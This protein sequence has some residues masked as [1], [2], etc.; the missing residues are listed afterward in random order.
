MTALS[1]C[2]FND[3]IPQVLELFERRLTALRSDD[4]AV[5][6]GDQKARAA[7]H[8]V[9]RWH[10]G[11]RLREVM[12][13]WGHLH[14]ILVDELES[15]SAGHRNLKP[16]VMH[17]ARRA[18]SL[19]CSEGVS[20]SAARYA[21]FQQ[22]DAMGRVR[23]LEHAINQIKALERQRA[24]FWR[25]AAH[26]LRGNLGVVRSATALLN[27]TSITDPVRSQFMAILDR[28]VESL[29]TLLT[30][31]MTL[32]RLEAGQERRRIAPFD[33]AAALGELCASLEPG[34]GERGLFLKTKGP[35]TLP[36]EGD[37]MRTRRIAQ[38]L[39]LNAIKY[40]ERGG[41]KVEWNV[42]ANGDDEQ[43]CL[44]VEDT[45]PGFEDGP[46][47]P[48]ARLLKQS[49]EESRVVEEEAEDA[50]DPTANP[51]PAPT[52]ASQST[53][54]PGNA[55]E[56]VG[57]SIVKRLCELLDATLELD[58]RPGQGSTFRVK[59]PRRYA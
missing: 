18:L 52:L 25:E 54:R 39:V 30:D 27:G 40:T 23:D 11:Y 33:A 29:N 44:C 45:G 56:G 13:E 21:E 37:L 24:Q 19:L 48:L 22:V 12:R 20:E 59:F 8:G 10:H 28:N 36:V 9:H 51:E 16:G 2:Q 32:A 14:L 49:T 53:H 57:L 55:G 58:T 26:D 38:N 5:W 17:A 50:G 4:K 35:E 47:T 43:W 34:A 15:Y 42:V 1:R 6:A 3:H 7:E 41:V 31:L 46:V